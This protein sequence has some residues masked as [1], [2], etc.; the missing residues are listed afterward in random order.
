M[1]VRYH[2]PPHH[3]ILEVSFADSFVLL[4]SVAHCE[5]PVFSR[6]HVEIGELLDNNEVIISAAIRYGRGDYCS[7]FLVATYSV[8]PLS[9]C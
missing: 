1:Q 3:T 7:L 8:S 6:P 2:P 5:K 9:V 4:H